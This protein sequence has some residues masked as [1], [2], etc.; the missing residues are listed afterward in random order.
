[1][2]KIGL[3]EKKN[4]GRNPSTDRLARVFLKSHSPFKKA[5]NNGD[6]AEKNRGNEL[7]RFFSPFIDILVDKKEAGEQRHGDRLA[8]G[9]KRN[10]SVVE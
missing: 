9:D 3:R 5:V 8:T 7:S 6:F 2:R 1:M 10:R 4:R